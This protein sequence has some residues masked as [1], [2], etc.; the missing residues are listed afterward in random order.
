MVVLG[1]DTL[2]CGGELASMG[3]VRS[4]PLALSICSGSTSF[5]YLFEVYLFRLTNLFFSCLLFSSPEL[6]ELGYGDIGDRGGE[7]A[8]MGNVRSD[9][10]RLVFY[11]R[12]TSASTAPGTSRRMC[13]LTHCAAYCASSLLA[14][15]Q[16]ERARQTDGDR[17]RQRDRE[18]D[19]QRDKKRGRDGETAR[20]SE[21]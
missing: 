17:D 7:S 20:A 14:L 10:E 16:R 9:L 13:C 15:S 12:T 19:R 8:S 11:C 2:D 21:T 5:V 4:G 18:R 1:G 3:N 6:S